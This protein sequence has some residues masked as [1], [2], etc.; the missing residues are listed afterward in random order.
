[1]DGANQAGDHILQERIDQL[2][3]EN[4]LLRAQAEPYKLLNDRFKALQQVFPQMVWC[5]DPNTGVGDFAGVQQWWA[6][7]TG[8]S[9]SEQSFGEPNWM[10]AIHEEDRDPIRIAWEK[11]MSEG[12]PFEVQYRLTL[13]AG[14]TV[15]VF[16]K[17][18]PIK[19]PDGKVS[20]WVGTLEDTTQA[21]HVEESRRL[22]VEQ[23]SAIFDASPLAIAVI[24]R[25][26]IVQLWNPM[27]EETFGWKSSEAVGRYPPTIPQDRMPEHEKIL[28]RALAGE[29]IVGH[30]MQLQRADGSMVHTKLWAASFTDVNG[31]ISGM[32]AI[33]ADVSSELLSAKKLLQSEESLKFAMRGG[34][35]GFWSRDLVA[36]KVEWSAE[37]E[38]LFGF[39]PGTFSGDEQD[40]IDLIHPA[41]RP[42]LIAAVQKSIQTGGDYSVE[43]RFYRADGSIGQMDGRGKSTLNEDG[44]AIRIDG[45]GIDITDRRRIETLI[46]E[47][48]I[49]FRTFVEMLPVIGW[50][51]DGTGRIDF[52]NRRFAEFTGVTDGVI[53]AN[54]WA[55]LIHPADREVSISGFQSSIASARPWAAKH[56]LKSYTGEYRWHVSRMEPIRDASGAVLHWFGTSTDIHDQKQTEEELEAR[57][58][59]RTQELMAAVS[60]L[61]GFTYTVSHDLRAPLRAINASSMIL[62]EELGPNLTK[63]QEALLHR[64]AHNAKRLGIL[65]DELLKLSRLNRQ[66]IEKSNVDIS[67]MAN[68]VVLDLESR[69]W[70]CHFEFKVHPKMTALADAKQ[71]RF[72]LLNLIENACKFSPDGGRIEIGQ[73]DGVFFV[74]DSGIGFDERYSDKLFQPFERLV[75]EKEYPG[76]GIGLANV[77]RIVQRHG[78]HVWAN[79]KLGVGSTF[80]FTLEPH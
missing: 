64:Q 8:Q 57:V 35:M 15:H 74:K 53:D 16:S 32:I 66:Q 49:R 6:N 30:E 29:R 27:A 9:P 55:E 34:K 59:E 19:A 37:L 62:L 36:G 10:G 73:D 17:A 44:D 23:F 69:D 25:D 61:E 45:F 50:S 65:I 21:Q 14:G 39:E 43:F 52:T 1:M 28:E 13:P 79:S 67:A 51:L 40:F 7:L 2:T 63:D 46:A 18:V 76:T 68:E 75:S 77:L 80:Y 56:R 71:V 70:P 31:K 60:D 42:L 41:D 11:A 78:G 47:S 48:E 24:D 12:S 26:G 54:T 72:V 4:E 20:E 33:C 3:R 22:A 58:R 5:W 38:E